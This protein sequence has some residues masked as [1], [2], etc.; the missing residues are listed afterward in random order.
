MLISHTLRY[1]PAQLLSPLG[2][3][4]SMILWTHYLA[5]ADMGVYTLVTAT[6]EMA[7]LVCL[8]W[9][10]V[11]ALRYL[12]PDADTGGRQRYLG[13]ENGVV[14]ASVLGSAAA[15]LASAMFLPAASRSAALVAV[16]AAFFATK[17][18]NAHYAE[19]ARAQAAFLPY[20][21]LQ[22]AGPVG[23][24]ALGW[25]ALQHLAPTATVLLGAYA[26][27]QAVGT[28]LALPGL[29]MSWRLPRPD[30][31]L[32]RSAIGFGGP[33]LLLAVLG[34]VGENYIRYLVQW[35]SGAASLG[36][37]IVG[38]ALGRRCASVASMVVATAAF[39]IAARL[40]NEGKRDEALAQLRLNATLL[41]AILL[42]VTAAVELLGPAL[43]AVSV[44]PEYR[45]ITTELLGLSMLAGAVRNL[46]MHVTDQLMVLERRITLVA[47]IDVVEIVACAAATLVG[48]VFWG[49]RGA[50]IGQAVGSLLALALSIYWA[51]TRLGFRWPWAE[52]AKVGLA[53]GVMALALLPLNLQ[54]NR[55]GLV[56]GSAVG[57]VVYAVAVLMV[58]CAA[59]AAAAQRAAAQPAGLSAAWRRPSAVQVHQLAVQ[60][61]DA[62]RVVVAPGEAA[63]EQPRAAEVGH[64]VFLGLELQQRVAQGQQL[65]RQGAHVRAHHRLRRGVEQLGHAQASAAAGGCGTPA[66]PGRSASAARPPGSPAGG[67]R[68]VPGPWG[69]RAAR[70]ARPGPCSRGRAGAPRASRGVA[71]SRHWWLTGRN[72]MRCSMRAAEA[73][74]VSA[75]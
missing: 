16:M 39:P 59:T 43:V 4:V 18:F 69:G 48:L 38:W 12:P 21:V 5:P 58:F 11:Y 51:Q 71:T 13:T 41:L 63:L 46:H 29:G 52:T 65:A 35:H 19:R 26:L 49:L 74:G 50:V 17:A 15:A 8:G 67:G 44:A 60:V 10:S 68:P 62:L 36:L 23:G 47:V 24:L 27:A 73:M 75:V 42:P 57:A 56:V 72:P 25:L 55:W 9:F 53:C 64:Q 2:Q 54:P 34:W 45:A 40:L 28:L 70:P 3:L 7:F 6:Q 33:L 32:L 14:L 66:A 22:L 30:W 37:M 20:T 61:V 1:L 31:T